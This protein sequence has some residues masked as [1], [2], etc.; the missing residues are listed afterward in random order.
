[1]LNPH[2]PSIHSRL[3]ILDSLT[4]DTYTL[5]DP[6][7]EKPTNIQICGRVYIC[8]I[9]NDVFVFI[10]LSQCH[11]P[12]ET[13]RRNNAGANLFRRY[14]CSASVFSVRLFRWASSGVES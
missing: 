1:M 4:D 3:I 10:L 6:L 13:H 2:P 14:S 12:G 7:E 5:I 11:L 9:R 8:I